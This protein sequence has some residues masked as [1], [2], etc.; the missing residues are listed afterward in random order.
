MN[1]LI[2]ISELF[3]NTTISDSYFNSAYY[4][5]DNETHVPLAE[6]LS[7]APSNITHD[8]NL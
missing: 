8:F 1:S 5:V 2:L 7:L 6:S 3:F 4:Y